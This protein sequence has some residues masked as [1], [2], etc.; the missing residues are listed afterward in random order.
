MMVCDGVLEVVA[1][2]CSRPIGEP[3]SRVGREGFG[4]DKWM[5]GGSRGRH[6]W[7]GGVL[8]QNGGGDANRT[9]A[10]GQELVGLQPDMPLP[11]TAVCSPTET[12]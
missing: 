10:L 3:I 4:G 7:G 8:N 1:D 11:E 5:E 9:R 2:G 6:R 12:I